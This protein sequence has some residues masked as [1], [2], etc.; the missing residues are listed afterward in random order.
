MTIYSV[1]TATEDT[2]SLNVLDY[3]NKNLPTQRNPVT[4]LEPEEIKRV[5]VQPVKRPRCK[6]TVMVNTGEKVCPV[7][8]SSLDEPQD[9]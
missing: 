5:K 8:G 4:S 6:L 7:C 9:R 1:G 2:R 3:Q